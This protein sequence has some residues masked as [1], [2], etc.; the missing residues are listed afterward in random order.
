MSALPSWELP[1]HVATVIGVR[2]VIAVLFSGESKARD[3]MKTGLCRLYSGNSSGDGQ[4]FTAN[5]L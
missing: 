2:V 5:S 4:E 3:N 1:D